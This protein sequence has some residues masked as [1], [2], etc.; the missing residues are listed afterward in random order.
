MVVLVFIEG[1]A[2]T[3]YAVLKLYDRRFATQLRKDNHIGAWSPE[4]ESAYT[5]FVRSGG[6]EKFLK[7]LRDDDEFEEPEGGWNDVENEAYLHDLCLDMYN[8]ETSAYQRLEDQQGITVPQLIAQVSLDTRPP[9]A[10]TEAF[11]GLFEVKGVLLEYIRGFTLAELDTK[12]PPDSW[13]PIV[14]QA[15]KIVDILSDQNILNKDVRS[16]NIL[17]MKDKNY[18]SGYRVVMIDFA[19]CIFRREDESDL[20]WGRAKW[21]QD[22]EGAIGMVMQSRLKKIGFDLKYTRSLRYLEWAEKDEPDDWEIL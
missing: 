22:E 10:N 8:A 15:I 18:E 9:D 7:R 20:E 14:D 17:A 13:Q 4:R 5:A 16:S 19:Q 11:G 6:A 3:D 2:E 21:S 1:Q 12:A